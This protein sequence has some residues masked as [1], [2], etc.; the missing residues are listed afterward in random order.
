MSFISRKVMDI[1]PEDKKNNC[2]CK[3]CKSNFV[4]KADETYWVEQGMY[5][6]KVVKCLECNCINVVRYADGFNQNPNWNKRY[7]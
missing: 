2:T 6:E 4:F 1:I 7:F 5:S 3:K